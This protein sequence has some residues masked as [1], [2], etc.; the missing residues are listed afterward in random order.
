MSFSAAPATLPSA[1]CCRRFITVRSRARFTEP[2]RI[3]GASRAALT[4][5]EY[6]KFA[7]DALKE[8]L[9]TGEYDEAEVAK[10]TAR[11][12][13]VSVDAQSDAGLGSS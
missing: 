2:T 8:H 10:F 11:L 13:Y 5:E 3:I 1:S 7:T 4:H 9:K 12:F 6:R